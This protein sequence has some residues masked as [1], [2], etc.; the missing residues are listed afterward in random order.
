MSQ[1]NASP[2]TIFS[3][4]QEEAQEKDKDPEVQVDRKGF[5]VQR[6]SHWHV[7]TR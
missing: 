1:V 5:F 7:H 6:C 2:H 4:A 3:L